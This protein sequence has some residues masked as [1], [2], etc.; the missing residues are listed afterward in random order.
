MG[1]SLPPNYR[2]FYAVVA[3]DSARDVDERYFAPSFLMSWT[4]W[5]PHERQQS[6]FNSGIWLV[7]RSQDSDTPL[8][9]GY[10]ALSDAAV[11]EPT[12]ALARKPGERLNQSGGKQYG[13]HRALVR[14]ALTAAHLQFAR[15]LP[16]A[17]T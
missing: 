14:A 2:Y 13:P 10:G 1:L 15:W 4:R 7:H 9:C 17:P 12:I 11:G 6:N 5:R 3:S 16:G 8:M